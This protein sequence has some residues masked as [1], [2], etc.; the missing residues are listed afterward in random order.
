M[1]RT[2]KRLKGASGN[3]R[4]T[5]ESDI[6]PTLNLPRLL[7][8]YRGRLSSSESVCSGELGTSTIVSKP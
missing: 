2:L 8:I 1:K 3:L 5:S 4:K 6:S 7:L